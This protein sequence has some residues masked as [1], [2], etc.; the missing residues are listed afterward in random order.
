MAK[1]INI[2]ITGPIG[3]GVDEYG[4]PVYGFMAYMVDWY[5][6]YNWEDNSIGSSELELVTFRLNTNGG[7][8]IQGFEILA[9]MDALK[10]RGVKVEV[11]NESRAYSMGSLLLQ[12]ASKGLRKSRP[13]ALFMAHKP[14]GGCEGNADEMRKYADYLDKY[15]SPMI[16]IYAAASGKSKEEVA[17]FVREERFM[18]AE[19]TKAE[20]FIDEILPL[21]IEG[22][23]PEQAEKKA[24]AFYN[25]KSNQSELNK[26]AITKEEKGSLISEIAAMFGLKPK[27]QDKQTP[28]PKASNKPTPKPKAEV[29][30]VVAAT[31]ETADG[32]TIHYEGEELEE[33]TA[34]FAD[35]ELT[36]AL[37]DGD[38]DLADGRTIEV[39]EGVVANITEA[40]EEEEE[41]A[42]AS[43]DNTPVAS[44][45]PAPKA[46]A[47]GKEADKIKALQAQ[48]DELKKAV[49]GSG[50]AGKKG[51]QNFSEG[52]NKPKANDPWNK[53]AGNIKKKYGKA[54]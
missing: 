9:K 41:E 36:E 14:W 3:E 8:V 30:E 27:A 24:M 52:G 16:T 6:G 28:K 47:K 1:H 49:P 31:T 48:L 35:A 39:V 50:N 2:P 32:A 13:Y 33:G 4:Y 19:E 53:V 21:A 20:G 15:E 12:G 22:V 54:N 45:K 23:A 42:E 46:A 37:E 25:P 26:M 44:K 34:V 7:C 40:E 43:A 10:E 5:L 29:V 51:T 11:I 18:T 17:D 38:Y